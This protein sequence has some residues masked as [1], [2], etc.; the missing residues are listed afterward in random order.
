MK[1][2]PLA[3]LKKPT[4]TPIPIFTNK[5]VSEFEASLV[6]K[7]RRQEGGDGEAQR[8]GPGKRQREKVQESNESL[9]WGWRRWESFVGDYKEQGIRL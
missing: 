6:L 4:T 3:R 5:T 1:I 7:E 2:S 8:M 9:E